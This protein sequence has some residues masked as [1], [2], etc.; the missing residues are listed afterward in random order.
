M[1]ESTTIFNENNYNFLYKSGLC[2]AAKLLQLLLTLTGL[3]GL[4]KNKTNPNQ[5]ELEMELSLAKMPISL[6]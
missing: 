4:A 1:D 3:F 5:P 6:A 2:L